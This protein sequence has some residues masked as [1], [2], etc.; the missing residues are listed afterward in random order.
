[1]A[2]AD[3]SSL[4]AH[5]LRDRSAV[6]RPLGAEAHATALLRGRVLEQIARALTA[7][8]LDALLVKGAA[9]ALTVYPSAAARPMN[10]I[11]LLVRPGQQERVVSA[12][13][14]WRGQTQA[15]AC[16][17]YRAEDRP[18]SRDFLGEVQLTMR[19]GAMSFAVE[20]H[21]SLDKIVPRPIPV[22]NL[23]ERAREAPSLPGLFLPSLEDH[24]LLVALHAAGNELRLPTN[25]LDLELLLRAGLDLSALERRARA[26]RLGTVMYVAMATLRALGSASVED[27]HVA[28]FDPGPLR[29]AAL[30]RVYNVGAFP[31]AR[32]PERLG[33]PWILRHAPLREELGAWSL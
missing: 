13:A 23:F 21:T 9:L 12:L 6:L 18:L 19:C 27:G 2:D 5:L 30:R 17:V 24:A 3:A 32:G 28:I 11:D 31:V 33:V 29:R 26:W 25:L 20:V 14:R 15:S 8:R 16:D 7:E 10:D 1:M 4:L 22:L